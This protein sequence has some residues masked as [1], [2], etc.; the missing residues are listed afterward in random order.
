MEETNLLDRIMK[1]TL[2]PLLFILLTNLLQ[3]QT[4]EQYS[5]KIEGIYG[6][7][8]PHNQHVKPLIKDPVFGTELSVE[9]Q[10]MG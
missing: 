9:F 10:T 4:S 2:F 3:A 5:F 6:D 8:I 7:I 1:Y